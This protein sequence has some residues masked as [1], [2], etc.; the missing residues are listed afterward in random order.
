MS[1]STDKLNF[2][3]T[4]DP[5]INVRKL[6]K[7]LYGI[8]VAP[9]ENN[10]TIFPINNVNPNGSGLTV[11]ANPPNRNVLVNRKFYLQVKFVLTFVG[12]SGG[13]GINLL[14]CAGLPHAVGVSSGNAYYDAP[15]ANALNNAMTNVNVSLNGDSISTNLSQYYRAL[16]RYHNNVTCQ[17]LNSS[18]TPTML[19][20]FLTYAEGNGFARSELRGYGDNPLQCPR[21]GFINAL[22]TRNDSTGLTG[23]TAVVELTLMEAVYLS[24]LNYACYDDMPCFY[25]LD[26]ISEVI[27]F[28]GP[29]NGPFGGLMASLWSHAVAAVTPSTFTS[30]GVTISFANALFQYFTPPLSME[31]P[32]TLVYGYSEPIYYATTQQNAVGA[33]VSRT[34]NLDNIQLNSIPEKMYLWVAQQD[35]D[36]SFTSSDTYFSIQKVNVTFNNKAGILS[37]AEVSDLY[38][39]CVRNGSNINYRQFV[40][41]VGSVICLRFGEDIPLPN[42]LAAGSRGSFNISA[43]IDCTNNYAVSITPTL[44]ALFVHSGTYTISNGVCSKQVGLLTE[45]E[46]LSSQTSGV[47]PI[48]RPRAADALGGLSWGEIVGFFKK[49]GRTGIDIA[50]KVVPVLAPEYAPVVTGADVLAQKLG[51]GKKRKAKG[52]KGLTRAEM[53]KMMK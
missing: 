12:T 7:M 42:L 47:E 8:E 6:D 1:L 50:K 31:I 13:A 49:L 5:R 22:V 29:G 26:T 35:Q 51:F 15:R 36:R 23:D 34:L 9:T 16:T 24:P 11:I 46:V 27:T 17:D 32:K 48:V 28:G 3:P 39:M 20:Q 33:G 52:G 4:I 14:Q 18:Y 21:G 37:T 40:K 41:D 30:A 2:I 44:S 19:D 38:N 53:L 45:N 25:G 43:K 10:Y